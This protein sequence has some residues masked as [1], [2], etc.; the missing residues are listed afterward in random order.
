VKE[1]NQ[2]KHVVLTVRNADHLSK[3]YLAWFKNKL[4]RLRRRSIARNWVGGF[5]ALEITNEGRGWHLHCHL[6]IEARWIDARQLAIEWANLV[7]QDFAI[8]KVKDARDVDYVKEL[9]KYVCKPNQLC[10]W[11]GDELHEFITTIEGSRMFGVFGSL[12][13]KRTEFAE[14]LASIREHKPTCDCGCTTQRFFSALEWEAA[15]CQPTPQPSPRP[16]PSPQLS[17][18]LAIPHDPR[19]A[20]SIG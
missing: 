5:Y 13:K 7:G 4:G 20:L 11:Q 14:W 19:N 10:K 3:K 17:F 16:P 1:C 15:G 9:T 18:P 6:L 8:V 12:Y 2:P